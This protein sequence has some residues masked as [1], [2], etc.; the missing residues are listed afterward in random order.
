LAPGNRPLPLI[1]A[2]GSGKGGV[3]K[4][5]VSAN[6]AARLAAAGKQVLCV[7]LDVGGANLHT[8]FGLSQP[9]ETLAEAVMA[10]R[11]SLFDV[12]VA[13]GVPG[14]KIVAGGREEAWGGA[15]SLDAQATRTLFASLYEAKVRGVADIV[16]LDLGAGTHR[17]T[18]DFFLAAHVGLLTVLPEPTSIEN[19]YQFLKGALLRL[20]DNVGE[21]AGASG[22]AEEA[23]AALVEIGQGPSAAQGYADRLRRLGAVYP[24]FV[25]QV[26]LALQGRPLGI[27]INQVRSQKDIDVGRSME[28]IAER[29]FG[30]QSR[31]T[32]YLNYDE[33]AWKSLRNRRLLIM[34]FP[35]SVLSR[36]FMELA[37]SVVALGATA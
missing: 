13:S 29:Y 20:V 7:D 26:A 30:F 8:Y 10:R 35:H 6:L 21:R 18:I 19:A 2:V 16:I 32:G 1:V 3:G 12:A 4:S 9:A 36:R 24:G 15:L 34:D 11:R 33:A 25:S 22:V 28:L 37:R 17:H 23:K 5:L 31:F 14:L 27:A